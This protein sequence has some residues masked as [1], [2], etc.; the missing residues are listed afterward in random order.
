MANQNIGTPKFFPDLIAY[1]RARG[2]VI[3]TITAT[4]GSGAT[5]TRGMQT[6]TV[7]ELFDLRPLNLVDFDTSGDTDARVLIN[8]A[9]ASASFKQNFIA[10]LNHN[11]NTAK[12][13]IRVFAGD[14]S[15]DI[16]AVNGTNADIADISTNGWTD[17][18]VT[19]VVNADART[20]SADEKSIVIEPATDGTTVFTFDEQDLRYWAVQFEGADSDGSA[21]AV[22]GDFDGTTDLSVGGIMIGEAYSMAHAPDL[23]VKRSIIYDRINIIESDGGQRFA[24]ATSFGRTA[25][26]TSKSPFNLGTWGGDSYGGRLA[27]DL[28]FSYMSSSDIM[29]EEY[30]SVYYTDDAVVE[31]VWNVVDG[32]HRPFIFSIDKSTQGNLAESVMMFARFGQNSLDMTQVAHNIFNLSMRI[33]EE[34]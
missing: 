22:D 17:L 27:F 29:P 11:L 12:G 14:E 16:T 23:S 18:T 30:D 6:G 32:P 8:V 9:F 26:S 3:G 1:H 33:E 7:D 19:D 4:G 21:G 24:N 34:F 25:S 31:D 5:A 20:V 2:S 28:N 13:K 15:T 10:I